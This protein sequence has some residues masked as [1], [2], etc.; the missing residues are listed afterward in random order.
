[1]SLC[2]RALWQFRLAEHTYIIPASKLERLRS[3]VGEKTGW[4]GLSALSRLSSPNPMTAMTLMCE[5]VEQKV[6]RLSTL[7]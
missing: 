4:E 2:R 5:I 3:I 1:M 6:R 7:A